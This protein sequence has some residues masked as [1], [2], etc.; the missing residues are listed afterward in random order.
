MIANLTIFGKLY[1][2]EFQLFFASWDQGTISQKTTFT[3]MFR[4]TQFILNIFKVVFVVKEKNEVL[5]DVFG[6][7][8]DRSI[9]YYMIDR[10]FL[11]T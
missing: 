10:D 9:F 11:S 4:K 8:S 5:S 2:E 6:P 1:T 3:K 7:W